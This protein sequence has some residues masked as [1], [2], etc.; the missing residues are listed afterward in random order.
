MLI[1]LLRHEQ[2]HWI[3]TA[4]RVGLLHGPDARLAGMRGRYAN[5]RGDQELADRFHI[6][7]LIGEELGPSRNVA[8][9]HDVRA[10]LERDEGGHT[11]PQLRT[12]RWGLVPSWAKDPKIGSRM[13]N[14]RVETITKKPAFRKPAGRRRLIV[15]MDGYYEW[16]AP[17]SGT[18]RKQPFYL[19]DPNREPLAAAGLY[20]LWRDPTKSDDDPDRWLWS[21][22]V[23]TTRTTDAHGHVHD[24]SPLLLP[25]HLWDTWLDPQLT[26]GDQVDALIASVPEPHLTPI[27]VD[28]AVGNV[29][30]D[31][32]DLVRPVG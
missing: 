16:Q 9:T 27:K 11:M 6:A 7:E 25:D 31:N 19:V 13:I 4:D 2:R 17:E 5:A 8:P 3:G 18:G 12:L 28:L 24:R 32:P 29:R 26:D 1:D 14:A 21:L 22:T 15:P 10:V 23:I 30:N 20:E